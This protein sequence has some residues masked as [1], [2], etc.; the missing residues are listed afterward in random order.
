MTRLLALVKISLLAAISLGLAVTTVE[1][2]A[3]Y[4]YEEPTYQNGKRTVELYLGRPP[5]FSSSILR[6]P[7]LLYIN[8][9]N[10]TAHGF[11]QHNS[12]GYRNEE[13]DVEK[14][15]NVIRIL[16]LGGST[17]HMWPFVKNPKDIWTARLEAKLQTLTRRKVEVINAGLPYGT[18]VSRLEMVLTL[19]PSQS[20][21]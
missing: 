4:L 7:Y 11:R 5:R 13:F 20:V 19:F 2:V 15:S 14:P 8:T 3:G 16:C 12:L 21:S 10:F 1:V 9:P 17:T 6:H 18:S